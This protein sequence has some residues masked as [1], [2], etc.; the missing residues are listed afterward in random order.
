MLA[1]TPRPARSEQLTE[2]GNTAGDVPCALC[3]NSENLRHAPQH[4][5]MPRMTTWALLATNQPTQHACTP[6]HTDTRTPRRGPT[7]SLA[8]YD[9]HPQAPQLA[10]RRIRS[11]TTVV[12]DGCSVW[13]LAQNWCVRAVWS[14]SGRTIGVAASRLSFSRRRV[15]ARVSPCVPGRILPH[16]TALRSARL[17]QHERHSSR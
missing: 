10:H 4:T 7:T 14:V 15:C 3:R 12:C 5:V 6:T 13:L 9:A 17:V 2:A 11:G 1:L 16:G 8:S